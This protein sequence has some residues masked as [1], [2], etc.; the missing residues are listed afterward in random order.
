MCS[1]YILCHYIFFVL[2]PLKLDILFFMRRQLRYT[3]TEKDK[4]NTIE[5]FLKNLGFSHHVMVQ[6]KRT[7]NGIKRNGV[8]AYTNERLNEG[9]ILDISLVEDGLSSDIEPVKLD[10]RIVYEDEDILVVDKPAGMPIHPSI[11]NHDNTLANALLYYFNSR[12][13]SF[14]FRCINRLDRDTT[15]LTI[16]AKHSLSA[17]ILSQMVAARQIKRTYMAVVKGFTEASGTIDAPIARKDDSTI[18]RCVDFAKGERAV[19]HYKRLSYSEEKDLSLIE[20][21]LETGRTH[22]IRV[23]MKHIGHPLIGDFLYNPDYDYID[24]QALH[25]AELSFV[26]PITHEKMHFTA[27]LHGDMK[28]IL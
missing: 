15:G 6:L 25:S 2:F 24:R 21:K 16:I 11:N 20:L 5:F 7:E 26:H 1:F 23:H 13:E 27:P 3:I 28:C 4:D 22:Q 9:D 8:W 18:E 12:G 14:V 19:T 10:F 17:G